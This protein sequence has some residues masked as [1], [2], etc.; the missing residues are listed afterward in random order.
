[1]YDWGWDG[2]SSG[3]SIIIKPNATKIHQFLPKGTSN[4]N[5]DNKAS[6]TLIGF[7]GST[8]DA[9]TLME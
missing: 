3:Y 6:A 2:E 9:F 8:A 4:T 1:M 5:A 7:A